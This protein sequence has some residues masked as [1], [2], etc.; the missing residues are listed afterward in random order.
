MRTHVAFPNLSID[1]TLNRRL[2][3]FDAF[4]G[5]IYYYAVIICLGFVLA[6]LYITHEDKKLKGKNDRILDMVLLGLP[7]SIICARVYYVI[8][9]F[10]S[11]KDNL[12]DIFKV[13][14]GGIA[15]YGG[16]IGAVL[17]VLLYCKKNKLSVIYYLDL[18]AP[19]L[20]IGQAVGRWGNFVN[21]EAF[22]SVCSDK[23]I[24]GMMVNGSGPY[25]PTFF[26]ESMG[27]ILGFLILHFV[28]RNPR[29]PGFKLYFYMM[30]YGALRFFVENLRTD[31]LYIPDTNI[32][33]SALLSA[34]IFATGL[35]L[36]VVNYLRNRQKI[37]TLQ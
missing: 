13:W 3:D 30:W 20:M 11:Y 4:G 9:S 6:W 10:D 14:N 28:T 12:L 2:I 23:N 1:L 19:A 34:L 33:V 36:M 18:L 16:I 35:V 25:H 24:L 32:R 31:S 37:A 26:Y 21:G 5:G 8:F 22:G 29:F 15:I 17:T 27:N 7:L